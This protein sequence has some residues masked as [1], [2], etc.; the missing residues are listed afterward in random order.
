L[1]EFTYWNTLNNNEK[2]KAYKITFFIS[3]KY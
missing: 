2:I 3:I 1:V